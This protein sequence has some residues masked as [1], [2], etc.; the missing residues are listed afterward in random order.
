MEMQSLIVKG[1]EIWKV[2]RGRKNHNELSLILQS[3]F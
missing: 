3:D 2:H 1:K